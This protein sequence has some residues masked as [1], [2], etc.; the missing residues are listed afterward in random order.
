MVD[1]RILS[2]LARP[3]VLDL[4]LHCP[5]VFLLF[6]TYGDG[7]FVPSRCRLGDGGIF[8]AGARAGANSASNGD[9]DTNTRR[10]RAGFLFAPSGAVALAQH[11]DPV[12]DQPSTLSTK[13]CAK[14]FSVELIGR[15]TRERR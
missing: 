9:K 5:S 7:S 11:L 12:F 10:A 14:L 2:P 3:S 15:G 8:Q 6:E 1:P 13:S 4:L